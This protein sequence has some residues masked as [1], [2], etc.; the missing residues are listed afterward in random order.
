VSVMVWVIIG[1]ALSTLAT[2]SVMSYRVGRSKGF[3]EIFHIR[4]EA[5]Q[6]RRRM[7]DLTREAFVAMTEVAENV[8]GRQHSNES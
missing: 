1:V 4:M 6:A 7:H 5:A 2:V 8:S 3:G